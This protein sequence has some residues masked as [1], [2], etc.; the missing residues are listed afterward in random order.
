MN[1]Y[2]ITFTKVFE[3]NEEYTNTILL[4]GKSKQDVELKLRRLIN[5]V[6]GVTPPKVFIKSIEEVSIT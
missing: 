2:R 6:S 3:E 5:S 1:D 4:K